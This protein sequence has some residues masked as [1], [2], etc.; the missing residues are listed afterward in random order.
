[1]RW[2]P[3]PED[4]DQAFVRFEGFANALVRPQFPLLIKFGPGYSSL[5]GLTFDG[6]D[7]DKKILAE[8][9]KPVW[10]EVAKE[11]RSEITD[12]QI[13]AAARRLPPEYF[14]KDGTRL[15]AGLKSRRDKLEEHADDFYRFINRVV[16]VYC[17]DEHERVDAHRLENGDLEL[18]VG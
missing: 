6:W 7:V 17:T 11:L 8:L 18:S 3:I 14:A 2:Q 1:P 10:D 15:I 4:R 12:A 16:D 13:E 9:E 5:K